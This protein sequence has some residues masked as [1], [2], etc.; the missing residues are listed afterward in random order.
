MIH[1]HGNDRYKYS[2]IVADFSSNVWFE[3]PPSNLL[4]HLRDTVAA[5]SNYPEPESE[6]LQK[7]VAGLHYCAP[8]NCVITNGSVEAFYLIALAY[9]E[10]TSTVVIPCFS[11]YEDAC[12]MHGHQLQFVKNSDGWEEQFF[13]RQLVWFGNPNNPDGKVMP[14][15]VLERMLKNNPE[16]VFIIDEAYGDLCPEFQSAVSLIPYYRNFII[17]R[18]FTK[19]FAIPGLRLGYMLAHSSLMNNMRELKMPW[20]VNALAM[21]AGKYITEH[22]NQLI[23]D[24][25]KVKR[26]SKEFQQQLQS[27]TDGLTVMP[28][29]C[30][31]C[32]VKL[33]GTYAGK[34]KQFLIN[35]YGILIRDAS[36]FRGLDEKYIRL[37]VQKPEHNELLIEGLKTGIKYLEYE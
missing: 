4:D 35:E 28:S 22:Y 21:E 10:Y 29:D 20:T 2:D 17:V 5:V 26:V 12:R 19:N 27:V 9:R 8:E 11:E 34:L 30:N 33:N 31:Y 3:G 18:S 37:A 25:R 15:H 6:T 7:K 32:M 24:T 13:G 36:N 14:L 1:G 16:T 23:P